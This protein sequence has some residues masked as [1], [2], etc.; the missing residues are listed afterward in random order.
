[1]RLYEECFAG[2][3]KLLKQAP[4]RRLPHE[5]IT[6]AD[7]GK[8]QLIFRDDLAYELGSGKLP[9]MSG[10]ALTADSPEDGGSR[11]VNK[12]EVWLC[13][14]DLPELQND[15]P[16]ARIALVRVKEDAMGTGDA[17]YRTIRKI[18]YTRYH[19]NPEGFM[20]RISASSRKEAARISRKALKKGLD[21]ASVGKLFID[22]YHQHP[23]VEAVKLIFITQPDFPYGELSKVL[24]R[25]ENITQ[26]LDHL[27]NKVK[28]DCNACGLKE[29]C[30]EVEELCK[31][32]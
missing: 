20:L 2:M 8:N 11:S 3:E 18:E 31:T 4:I 23:A 16:Y 1:M 27:L 10:V 12:D 7:A 15:T 25:S 26:A 24:E 30:A 19:V 28:M 6:W 21:F 22:A 14:P 9:A 32:V 29:I 17:L 5:T 13:G